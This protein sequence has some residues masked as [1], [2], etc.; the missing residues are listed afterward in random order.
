MNAEQIVKDGVCVACWGKYE[1]WYTHGGK[2]CFI[3]RSQ[4]E[5]Q[6]RDGCWRKNTRGYLGLALAGIDTLSSPRL[7]LGKNFRRLT[8]REAARIYARE[9]MPMPFVKPFLASVR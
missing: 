2:C 4:Q 8:R 9:F 6:G 1:L 5:I 3:S 7:R